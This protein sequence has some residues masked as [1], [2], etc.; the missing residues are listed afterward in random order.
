MESQTQVKPISNRIL[1]LPESVLKGLEPEPSFNDFTQLKILGTGSFGKVFLVKHKKTNQLFAMKTIDKLRNTKNN[2]NP[3]FR[4]E[5]EIMY[6]ISHSNIV[7]LFSHFE[8]EKYC[9]F[10]MEYVENGSLFSLLK[11][12]KL[13]KNKISELAFQLILSVYYLHNMNPPIIHR[14]IKLENILIDSKMNV[15]LTDFGWSNYIEN[16]AIRKTFC[17]TP[18][19]FPPEMIKKQGHDH[20]V[21]IWC[22]GIVIFEMITGKQPF[23]GNNKMELEKNILE[24]NINWPMD[25]NL[26]A[27]SLIK[28]I[29]K[30]NPKERPSLVQILEH[31]FFRKNLTIENYI[32]YLKK[33][34][35]DNKKE[36]FIVSK[37][38]VRESEGSIGNNNNS[39]SN[40][41][42]SASTKEQKEIEIGEGKNIIEENESSLD[43]VMQEEKKGQGEETESINKVKESFE[44]LK[45]DYE[46]LLESYSFLI[47][48]NRET[49]KKISAYLEK[50]NFMNKEKKS[51]LS[52]IEEKDNERLSLIS[53]NEE[54][55]LNLIEKEEKIK[56]LEQRNEELKN[57]NAKEKKNLV[58]LY[59][60][61]EEVKNK[62]IEKLSL[63]LENQRKKMKSLQK[64]EEISRKNSI[65][66]KKAEENDE[67]KKMEEEI[68]K[69]KDYYQQLKSEK[70][71]Q[72]QQF[73]ANLKLK[74]EEFERILKE[75]LESFDEKKIKEN[76]AKKFLKLIDK[77]EDSLKQRESEIEKLKLKLKKY[78][79]IFNTIK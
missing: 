34:N 76:E 59:N 4:K 70:K 45:M 44:K 47:Q 67:M 35:I 8:D 31:P 62:E 39:T 50:E 48:N 46:Q 6:K 53:K 79:L 37:D 9:Y 25:M 21:D 16:D 33:P 30:N 77:Y 51:L 38:I 29:L 55:M 12:E 41:K 17:G 40:D 61:L 60:K 56:I 75:K 69:M 11:H 63:E 74:E 58:E 52:E 42:E 65:E 24:G 5:I 19:Y 13:S 72:E 66:E 64:E 14:D 15:K 73:K 1:P 23:K 78:E 36:P 68:Q 71:Q 26:E 27:K 2:D 32:S 49:K 18:S 7:K 43:I 22:I 3:Y 57:L 20:N 10:L 54:L 28:K